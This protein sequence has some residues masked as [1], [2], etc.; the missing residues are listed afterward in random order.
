ML[1]ILDP[2]HELVAVRLPL[3]PRPVA[4]TGRVALLDINKPRGDKLFDRLQIL[5]AANYPSVQLKRYK[6]LSCSK[7]CQPDLRELIVDECDL[8][9]EGLA[10]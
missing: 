4:L 2:T 3:A 1:Q 5:F 8:V 9:V 6:K 7:L 10:D